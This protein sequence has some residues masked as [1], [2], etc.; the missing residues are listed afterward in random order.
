MTTAM[1]EERKER[2]NTCHHQRRYHHY[3]SAYA[4]I[5]GKQRCSRCEKW[6]HAK[7]TDIPSVHRV[8]WFLGSLEKE[9]TT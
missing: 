2:C 9:A 1:T 8:Q 4:N 5:E 6:V 7:S 3:S